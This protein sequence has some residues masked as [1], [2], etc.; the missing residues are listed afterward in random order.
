M[1][2]VRVILAISVLLAASCTAS[3]K[4]PRPSRINHIV[5]I[6]L[7]DAD[8]SQALIDDCDRLL[9]GIPGVVAYHCGQHGDFGRQNIDSHYDVGLA[10]GF[11][12]PSAYEAYVAH[13]DHVALIEAWANRIQAIRIHDVVDDSP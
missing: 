6:V 5:F 11:D 7:N 4:A 2:T 3:P 1:Y 10:I 8:Q 12:T 9:P 13:D